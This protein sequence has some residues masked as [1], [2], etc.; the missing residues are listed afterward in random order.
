MKLATEPSSSTNKIRIVNRRCTVFLSLV[1]TDLTR[2][3]PPRPACSGPE[4][5]VKSYAGD[6]SA[7]H[8]YYRSRNIGSSIAR[9]KGYR[10]RI[11]LSPA[12]APHG[13][14]RSAFCHYGFYGPPLTFGLGR[15]Q[16]MDA[17][18]GDAP[19][20]DN[21][22]R[23]SVTGHFA[24]NCLRPAH[25]REAESVGHAE[26]RYRCDYAGRRAGN[27]PTPPS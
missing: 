1:C 4:I 7:I 18:S 27:D 24:R 16:E 8:S 15:V 2:T 19:W 25:Q 11:F 9:E 21:I 3:P 13:N 14:G 6:H 5:F 17:F 12:V 23:N 10:V 22:G 20:Q 26:V